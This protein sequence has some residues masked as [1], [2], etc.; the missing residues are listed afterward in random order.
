MLLVLLGC[1]PITLPV[2]TTEP[3]DTNLETGG[4]TEDTEDTDTWEPGPLPY[5][6]VDYDCS[7]VPDDPEAYDNKVLSGARAWHGMA[8]SPEGELIGWDGWNT[9]K[10]TKYE[11]DARSWLP[12]YS[13]VE[14]IVQ[15]PNGDLYTSLLDRGEV[16]RLTPEGGAE[17]LTSNLLFA[18]GM[19][20]RPDGKFW[21]ADGHLSVLDPETGEM[22]RLLSGDDNWNGEYDLY[23]DVQLNL[24]STKLY[25]VKAGVTG[26]V[27]YVTDVDEDLNLVGELEP[28]VELPG[29]WKDG[30]QVDACGYLW[31][32]DYQYY[33]LY[34]ISPDGEILT[35]LSTP[36]IGYGHGTE[37]GNGV[38]GW[39]EDAIYI[40]LPYNDAKV[41]EL[42]IGVPDGRFVRTW[43]GQKSWY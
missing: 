42:V 18:Y 43:K 40:P 27:M 33:A 32:P 34:R 2:D 16:V 1:T 17:R 26:S 38:G 41:R 19:T 37:W 11:D 25:V 29:Y 8:F 9:I 24:D 13:G 15:H 30:V 21:V 14:Q 28:F 5:P 36:E 31:V 12:G 22:E 4:D 35:V 23:R 39:R 10:K 3:A 7:A 6:T 20:Q